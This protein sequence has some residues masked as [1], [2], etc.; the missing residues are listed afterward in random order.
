MRVEIAEADR[1]HE[2]T[3]AARAWHEAGAIDDA[4]RAT[5]EARWADDRHR[6]RPAFRL[7]FFVFALLGAQAAWGFLALTLGSGLGE[8]GHGVLAAVVAAGAAL[9]SAAA[10]ERSRLRRF[11]VEEA[12]VAVALVAAATAVFLLAGAAGV[13]GRALLAIVALA[14]AFG[15]AAAALRWGTPLCGGLALAGLLAAQ[16]SLPGAR[17]L[18]L[19]TGLGA[20]VVATRVASRPGTSPAHRRRLDEASVVGWLAAYGAVHAEGVRRNAFA[21]FD[22]SEL[23]VPS[24]GLTLA[25]IAMF[26]LPALLLG[27]GFRRRDRLRLALGALLLLVS[28]GGA[29]DALDLR[30]LWAVLLAGGLVLLGAA[31]VARRALASAPGRVRAGFTDGALYEGT[32]LSAL[33]VA[34]AVAAFTPEARRAPEVEG[35]RGE[36]GEFGGGGASAKL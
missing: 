18:W 12:L 14:V 13:E 26:V 8:V 32:R 15:S 1:R 34:A 10:I 11:G 30:P 19:A 33:E 4:A 31:V 23:D 16:L 20:G 5:I 2:V 25:W 27:T 17:W 7:L 35:F 36:G 24:Y 28:T 21:V 6:T 29:A 3:R 22:R 9:A